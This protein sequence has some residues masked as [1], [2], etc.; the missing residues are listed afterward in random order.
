MPSIAPLRGVRFHPEAGPPE[1]GICPPYDVITSRDHRSLLAHDPHNAVR[2]ILGDNP[3]DTSGDAAEYGRRGE[4]LRAWIDEGVLVRDAEP[5]LYLYDME[6]TAPDGSIQS[7]RGVL[8]A[9]EAAPFGERGVFAHEETR[10]HVVKERL[11]LLRRSGV[12]TGTVQVCIDGRDGAFTKLLDSAPSELICDGRAWDGQHHRLRRVV[13]GAAITSFQDLLASHDGI[14]ADGHHRYTTLVQLGAE[15]RESGELP[16]GSHAHVLA[17]VGDLYQD[18]IGIYPTHR[19]MLWD[20]S[21]FTERRAAERRAAE[22]RAAD[23]RAADRRAADRRA[24]D[25]RATDRRATD[26]RATDRRATDRRATDSRAADMAR[27]L[28]AALDDGAGDPVK[29]ATADGQEWS[30]ACM[31]RTDAP[32]LSRRIQEFMNALDG[33]PQVETYHDDDEARARLAEAGPGALL[34]WMPAVSKQEFYRRAG[35]GEV[36]PPKTTYFLPKI[37][38]GLVARMLEEEQQR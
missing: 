25:R 4:R 14:I 8:C 22:R 33:A 36:F 10:P 24:A 16:A 29:L 28:A 35:G 5:S 13:D 32:T 11:D 1:R 30:L 17:A 9:L 34:C 38:S 2:W 6:F 26:R 27:R 7:W 15:L 3:D 18:G 20:G 19:M 21:S 37:S 23:R 12:D 31:D